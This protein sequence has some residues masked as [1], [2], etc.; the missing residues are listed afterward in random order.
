MVQ[1]GVIQRKQC[2]LVQWY[3]CQWNHVLKTVIDLYPGTYFR[4][5]VLGVLN[6]SE[7]LVLY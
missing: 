4:T 1:N 7:V 2:K 5:R 6:A 3:S